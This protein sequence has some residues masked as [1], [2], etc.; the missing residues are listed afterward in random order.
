[1]HITWVLS[2]ANVEATGLD[3]TSPLASY[4]Y[5]VSIPMRELRA[6]GHTCSWLSLRPNDKL[7]ATLAAFEQ[8]DVAIFSKNHTEQERVVAVLDHARSRGI[9][10]IVDVCD[11]YFESG[12]R[13]EPYYRS[14]VAEADAVTASCRQLATY[15]EQATGRRAHVIADP[16]EGPGGSPTWA[17]KR[18]EVKAVWFGNTG[19][20]QSLIREAEALP[21]RISGFKVD[22]LVLTREF[23][24]INEA[25]ERFNKQHGTTLT[26]RFREWSLQRNW[27]ELHDCDL[28]IIPVDQRERF[29]LAKGPNRLIEALWAGRFAVV[30]SIPS[31]DEFSPWAWVGDIADGI[32]WALEHPAEITQRIAAAQDHIRRLYSPAAIALN[33]ERT[34]LRESA[35]RKSAAS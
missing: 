19:N 33:W 23:P 24:G 25:F 32:G 2:A 20:M 8:T 34:L 4:R 12:A 21:Q 29:Y 18:S 26:L 3:L 31:Y 10:S 22:L 5:R 7:D 1:M 35:R 15:I 9:C 6:R 17:P 14:L 30:N 13:L 11:D 28:A 16:Y 27:T